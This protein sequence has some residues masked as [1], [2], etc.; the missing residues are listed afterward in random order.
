LLDTLRVESSWPGELYFLLWYTHLQ[1]GVIIIL[2][3]VRRTY[4]DTYGIG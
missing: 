1:P 3:E 4:F 2:T